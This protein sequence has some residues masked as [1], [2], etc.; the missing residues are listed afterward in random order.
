MRRF[1]LP[2]ALLT[3]LP[4]EAQAQVTAPTPAPAPT[5]TPPPIT[6]LGEAAKEGVFSFDYGVPTSPALTLAGLSQD[7]TT[8][9]S[10]ALKPFVLSLP[11][12]LSGSGG[13]S[14]ALDISP[15]WIFEGEA[16]RSYSNYTN[17]D[18]FLY[19]LA[20]RTRFN[21]ALYN[22]SDDKTDP[23]KK[24]ASRLAFGL[25]ASLLDSSDPLMAGRDGSG[26]SAW[27]QC[28]AGEE[29]KI[30]A[31]MAF[32]TPQGTEL[33]SLTDLALKLQGAALDVA[34]GA[35]VDP[36]LIGRADQVLGPI[37]LSGLSNREISGK[38]LELAVEVQKKATPVASANDQALKD[39]SVKLG[40]DKALGVCSDR[41]SSYAMYGTSWSVGGGILYRGDP[42]K[43]DHFKRGGEV[44]W[45]SFRL[46]IGAKLA[47][48]NKILRYLMVGFYVRRGF[49]EYLATGD[50][51][52]PEMEAN[53]WD[54]WVGLEH[55]TT[56]SKLAIQFGRTDTTAIDP[57]LDHFSKNRSRFMATA[58]FP[59]LGKETGIWLGA[60]YGNARSTVST[61]SD[62]TF[63]LTLE[64]APPKPANIFGIGK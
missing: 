21:A 38:L 29:P 2:F 12:V 56:S 57:A 47:A 34:G 55:F 50:G 49:G 58:S 61:E 59:L 14:A 45:S 20:Y 27:Q 24:K 22:G 4:V 40:I 13:Q 54:Y 60:A 16:E 33:A 36:R 32:N 48:D 7:K 5:P 62:K 46:P 3:P 8:V 41:A 9:Q 39:E 53:T 51:A 1:F 30:K 31:I 25:S 18:H 11:A 6:L 63:L 26:L 35:T 15:A 64:F 10:A 42:G 44:L 23:K 43:L 52:T 19:R 37:D 28:L 17:P